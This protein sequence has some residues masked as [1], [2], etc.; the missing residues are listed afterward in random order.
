MRGQRGD[1]MKG[2]LMSQE[3]NKQGVLELGVGIQTGGQQ[4]KLLQEQKQG[5]SENNKIY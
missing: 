2:Q 5:R 1:Y 4:E 3:E